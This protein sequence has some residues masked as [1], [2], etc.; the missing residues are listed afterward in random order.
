[1]RTPHGYAVPRRVVPQ[2]NVDTGSHVLQYG[3]GLL[4]GNIQLK[5]P[6]LFAHKSY[7]DIVVPIDDQSRGQEEGTWL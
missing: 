4:I 5:W 6:N 2:G 1:M 7:G 3:R